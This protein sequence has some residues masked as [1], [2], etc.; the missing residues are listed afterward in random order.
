MQDNNFDGQVFLA[1]CQK[2]AHQHRE[3]AI[4]GETDDLSIG[5]G[6]FEPQC[7]WHSICH[8]AV[9]KAEQCPTFAI[10]LEVAKNPYHSGAAVTRQNCIF[11]CVFIDEFCQIFWMNRSGIAGNFLLLESR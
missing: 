1:D 10:C 9:T 7:H 6:L 2:I 5:K 11:G 8:R 4:P 3:T